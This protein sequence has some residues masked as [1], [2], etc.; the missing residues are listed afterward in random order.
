[1]KYYLKLIKNIRQFHTNKCSECVYYIKNAT[2]NDITFTNI[3]NLFSKKYI[4]NNKLICKITDAYDC[5]NDVTK[6]GPDG[7][8]YKKNIRLIK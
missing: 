2:V 1:M 8:F 7:F 6:C 5:R 4:F 3:C